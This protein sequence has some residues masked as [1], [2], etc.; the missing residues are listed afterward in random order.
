MPERK[1]E[2]RV[3][4]IPQIPGDPFHVTV[5][6]LDTGI[7]VANALAEYDLFQYEHKVKPDYA[8]AGGIEYRVDGGE[9]DG[10]DYEDED[11][12]AWARE[13]VAGA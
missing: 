11:E 13:E 12:L 6:D 1:V 5:P 7:L 10:F 4:W 2:V 8:N 9:W 3:W